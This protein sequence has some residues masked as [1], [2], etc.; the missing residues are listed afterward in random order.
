MRAL[1][2]VALIARGISDD[3]CDNY[4]AIADMAEICSQAVLESDQPAVESCLIGYEFGAVIAAW[5]PARRP[6]RA[7]TPC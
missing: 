5:T 6:A 4:L 2:V 3:V 1:G 7:R